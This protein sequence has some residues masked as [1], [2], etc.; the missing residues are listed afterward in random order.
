[1]N[2]NLHTVLLISSLLS[3]VVCSN[4]D[5]NRKANAQSKIE[6]AFVPRTLPYTVITNPTNV[7]DFVTA[8]DNKWQVSIKSNQ[9]G[10]IN[11]IALIID[12]YIITQVTSL[13]FQPNKIINYLF[14]DKS[15]TQVINSIGQGYKYLGAFKQVSASQFIGFNNFNYRR[16]HLKITWTDQ[17]KNYHQ[18]LSD[19]LLVF[20]K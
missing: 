6:S 2:I 17:D 9:A 1:M 4:A 10:Q 13:Q 15:L 3:C 14:A 8:I 19:F 18:D 20:A 5:E 11:N 16:L 7:S 12:G